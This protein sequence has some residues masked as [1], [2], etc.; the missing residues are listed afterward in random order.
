MNLLNPYA[1]TPLGDPA[2]PGINV[3]RAIG[4]PASAVQLAQ[5]RKV[6]S[7]F[8]AQSRLS[9]APN[10]TA[11]GQLPDGSRYKIAVVGAMTTVTIWPVGTSGQQIR[12]GFV[13]IEPAGSPGRFNYRMVDAETKGGVHTG[14]WKFKIIQPDEYDALYVSSQSNF[15][16]PSIKGDGAMPYYMA[17]YTYGL[18]AFNVDWL[19][20]GRY[21]E[22]MAFDGGVGGTTVYSLVVDA[23]DTDE[24]QMPHLICTATKFNSVFSSVPRASPSTPAVTSQ[25]L[26]PVTELARSFA[27]YD[28]S[29]SGKKLIA[30]VPNI[31]ASTPVILDEARGLAY[32]VN[33]GLGYSTNVGTIQIPPP[34]ATEEGPPKYEVFN[35]SGGS[36]TPSQSLNLPAPTVLP[37]VAAYR[38]SWNPPTQRY[39]MTIVLTNALNIAVPDQDQD[40][41]TGSS[42][43]SNAVFN[44]GGGGGPGHWSADVVT[45]ISHGGAVEGPYTHT[46]HFFMA[47]P[48]FDFAGALTTLVVREDYAYNLSTSGNLSSYSTGQHIGPTVA[49]EDRF[50][51]MPASK[52]F[53]NETEFGVS[54]DSATTTASGSRA[55]TQ[56]SSATAKCDVF[57]RELVLADNYCT[58]AITTTRSELSGPWPDAPGNYFDVESSMTLSSTALFRTVLVYDPHLK[59]LC[60]SEFGSTLTYSVDSHYSATLDTNGDRS[61]TAH[62]S[63]SPH[64]DDIIVTTCRVVVEQNGSIKKVVNVPPTEGAAVTVHPK[65][66]GLRYNDPAESSSDPNGIIQVPQLQVPYITGKGNGVVIV[67]TF[68]AAVGY[69]GP[70]IATATFWKS[71]VTGAMILMVSA[72]GATTAT[73]AINTTG[74]KELTAVQ[75]E[76]ELSGYS[77]GGQ[78]I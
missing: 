45:T 59:L 75:A 36:F 56:T 7:S 15:L 72:D 30:E 33:T 62:I 67:S 13:F 43:V 29:F 51:A 69:G 23:I 57:G 31:V 19:G 2:A 9:M 1:F 25:A 17:G 24:G 32:G 26:A 76:L 55:I 3:L 12:G 16:R 49:W 60:Y 5:A 71:P 77:F 48:K 42:A 74:T 41:F 21:E 27:H 39:V 63:A 70:N 68:T 47:P 35:R 58:A 38:L 34:G 64:V 10:Q 4:A 61:G 40:I 11:I 6:F 54:T 66:P 44:N 52:S 28:W 37:P 78:T 53:D 73:M 14:K 50:S 18:R 8:C 20:T 22:V 65:W 46:K